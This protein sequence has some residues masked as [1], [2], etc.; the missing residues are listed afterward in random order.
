MLIRVAR[1]DEAGLLS[2]LAVRSK[3]HWGY[4]ED[5]LAGCRGELT[6]R[7][8]DVERRR[9]A[10]AERQGRVV[11]FVTVEGEPPDGELGMLFVDPPAIGSGVGRLL[12]EH[13]LSTARDLGFRR[14]TLEADPNAE[15]F[16]R[17]MGATR[18][19]S[20]ASGVVAGRTLPLMAVEVRP[21]PAST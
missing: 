9:T 1:P 19:G 14:L 13:A 10:V 16:Y 5:F 15:P 12:F 21:R 11:G 4:D 20:V 18:I 17:A 8:G 6:L 7:P 2:E 3:A